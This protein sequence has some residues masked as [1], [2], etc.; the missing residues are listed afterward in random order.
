MSVKIRL[1][2]KRF[3]R[4]SLL[5]GSRL[6]E[7]DETPVDASANN[8]STGNTNNTGNVNTN[9]STGNTN[10]ST[11]DVNNQ[12]P[13]VD[14]QVNNVIVNAFSQMVQTLNTQF[15]QIKLP[16]GVKVNWVQVKQPANKTVQDVL[17]VTKE[18]LQNNINAVKQALSQNQE[19]G[20]VNNTQT[21]EQPAQ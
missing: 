13:P 6:H 1:N 14:Q 18:Y 19:Q 10:A 5:I 3:L 4:E 15:A 20:N 12:V 17:A 16:E 9:A 7:A 21:T 2:N 11:G 8:A